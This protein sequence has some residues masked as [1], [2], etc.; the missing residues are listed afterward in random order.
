MIALSVLSPRFPLRNRVRRRQ[1]RAPPPLRVTMLPL[2]SFDVIMLSRF[3]SFP[4]I[5]PPMRV[6]V[7]RSAST[8]FPWFFFARYGSLVR[9]PSLIHCLE[10]NE[11]AVLKRPDRGR[12]GGDRA[13][14]VLDGLRRQP[15]RCVFLDPE[16]YYLT[17]Q[18]AVPF[19]IM[20]NHCEMQSQ[21]RS[22]HGACIHALMSRCTTVRAV[23]VIVCNSDGCELRTV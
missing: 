12:P 13:R 19:L 5:L 4:W 3:F 17:L 16:F 6:S 8:N 20:R 1:P 14:Q 7:N 2:Q 22:A 9:C 15:H 23:A 11:R 18:G 10:I 21:V